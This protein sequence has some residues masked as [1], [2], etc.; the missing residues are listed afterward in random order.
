MRFRQESLATSRRHRG[1]RR[2]QR[3]VTSHPWLQIVLLLPLNPQPSKPTKK[4]PRR[5][6]RRR[7]RFKTSQLTPK[8]PTTLNS[9]L[10]LLLQPPNAQSRQVFA[11]LAA[12]STIPK[13]E[14]LVTSVDRRRWISQYPA[15]I[16]AKTRS[17]VHSIYVKLASPTDMERKLKKLQHRVIGNVP[18]VEVF[19][20]AVFA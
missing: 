6:R 19:V 5:R 2:D 11:L 1:S 20:I 7:S 14:K 17:N 13:M 15:P 12:E 9:T 10:L 3:P 16:W 8:H 4:T 18:D